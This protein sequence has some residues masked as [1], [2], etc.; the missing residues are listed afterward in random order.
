[1]E[2][3]QSAQSAA[4]SKKNPTGRI[5]GVLSF[6]P[7]HIDNH[8]GMSASDEAVTEML[9]RVKAKGEEKKGLLTEDEFRTIIQAVL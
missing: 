7:L 3:P 8:W 4:I 5:C 6:V 9:E 2:K 1:M